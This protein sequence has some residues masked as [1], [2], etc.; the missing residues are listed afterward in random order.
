MI[1]PSTR[2]LVSLALLIAI[3]S[4]AQ[5]IKP[6]PPTPI[7]KQKA[8]LG[9]TPWN[10]QWDQIIEQAVPPEMLSA[11]VPHD[12][13]RYCPRFYELS[14]TDKRTFWAYFFRRSP[15]LRRV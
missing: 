11:A 2:S 7:D 3:A 4:P 6:A 9:G 1:L 10:P 8:E 14:E 15:E 12:V 13:R 5:Q